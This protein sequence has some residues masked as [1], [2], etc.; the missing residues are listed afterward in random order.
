MNIGSKKSAKAYALKPSSSLTKH[1]EEIS[2]YKGPI[3][4]VPSG[5][6]RNSLFFQARGCHVVCVDNNLTALQSSLELSQKNAAL[7]EFQGNKNEAKGRISPVWIDLRKGQWPFR[8]NAFAAII[9]VHFVMP[10]LFKFFQH[11]LMPGGYLFCE[12]FGGQGE[13]YLQLPKP[14][15]W[16]VILESWLEIK[17]YEE[18]IVGPI[19]DP[20][21]TVKVFGRKSG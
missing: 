2:S 7:S 17:R 10:E 21:V 4:D 12:T 5:S 20:A 15:E 11:S 19:S 3:L 13:N 1:F 18:K 14:G 8:S 16:K 9:N 6:G